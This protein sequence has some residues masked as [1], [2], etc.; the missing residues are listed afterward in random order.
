M[1]IF[2][3]V[4]LCSLYLFEIGYKARIGL[5]LLAHHVITV[6]FMMLTFWRMGVEP[7][8]FVLKGAVL[9][10]M[11]ATTEQQSFIA[12]FF[13]RVKYFS[14]KTVAYMFYFSAVST[15]VVKAI[16]IAFTTDAWARSNQEKICETDN[17]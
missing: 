12:L 1:I 9:L 10:G 15:F 7:R 5:P 6:A 13:F 11:T 17:Y 2:A 16:L 8:L 4:M 3:T 14:L